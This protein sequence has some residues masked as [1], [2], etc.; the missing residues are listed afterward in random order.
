MIVKEIEL[1]NVRSYR[2]ASIEFPLGKTLFEGDIG[3]GKSTILMAIEF[4]FFGLG[5]ETGSSLLR[6]GESE[7]RVRMIFDVDGKEYEILRGLSRKGTRVQQTGGYVKT[8]DAIIHLSPSEL[9][10]KI[11][12]ILQ[13]N[14]VPD[15]KAQSWIYR[16]AVYTPQEEM[17]SI[18]LLTPDLRLQILRRAFGIED[19]KAAGENANELAR[20][21]R[22]KA[23]NLDGKAADL[24]DLKSR[25]KRWKEQRDFFSEELKRMQKVESENIAQLENLKQEREKLHDEEMRL[26][27]L[28]NAIASDEEFIKARSK[29]ASEWMQEA[30]DLEKKTA[31]LKQK[32][33]D[34]E[35]A[36]SP[37]ARGADEISADMRELEAKSNKLR[38]LEAQM[39]SKV[40]EYHSILENGVCPVCDRPAE[41][42]EFIALEK[43]KKEEMTHVSAELRTCVSRLEQAREELEKTREYEVT[44]EKVRSLRDEVTRDLGDIGKSGSKVARAREEIEKTKARLSRAK[45]Q[46]ESLAD[47]GKNLE[48]LERKIRRADTHL[49]DAR[50]KL[51]EA[52][53]R[54]EDLTRQVAEGE[55]EAKVKERYGRMAGALKEN[56]IWLQDYFG[57]TVEAIERHVMLSI[58]Q[59]FNANF[60]KWFAMLIDDPEKE[61]RVDEN[62]TPMISQEGYEQEVNFL[63]GGERTSVALAYRLALNTLVQRV[64]TGMKSNLLILDEPTDGFS[65][66]Q[67][68][69]VREVLDDVV[70]PQ[71]IV[72]SHEKELESFADQIFRVSKARGESQITSG[73][74]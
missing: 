12:E 29:D 63:S 27:T 16:Y 26:S 61:V 52:K 60:Q 22:R 74:R 15:P 66:E 46:R 19:Y 55:E 13:F 68:G 3:S 11:L 36:R 7:G 4:A 67:L 6:V 70:C 44:R 40:D 58:N 49:K 31:R 1:Q 62:F 71:L 50:E 20:T 64:S 57:P 39:A 35:Q 25:V 42:H 45:K 9:K 73:T 69:N 21:I 47:L 38:S 5:S 10:E 43:A 17:K 30:E 51:T 37:T 14:E 41:P 65:Q 54:I 23:E 53:T 2:E 48:E 24:D 32:I 34:L 56:E 18:L 72:V 8:P 59:D 33:A 28:I